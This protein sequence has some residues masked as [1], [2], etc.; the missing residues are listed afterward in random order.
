M[1]D[2][3]S[4]II[5]IIKKDSFFGMLK[6]VW[7]YLKAKN[8]FSFSFSNKINS[9]KN[10]EFYAEEIDKILNN[11]K[12]D[13]V[14]IWRSSFGW[15]VPLYQRPQH[16]FNNLSKQRSLV[17]YEVT[18]VTD[19]VD[20]FQKVKDNLFLVNFNN[21]IFSKILL[22]KIELSNKPRYI[23]FYSTEW[24]MKLK[25]LKKYIEKGYKIIY[26]YIDDLSPQLAGTKELPKNVVDKYNYAMSDNKDIYVVVTADKLYKDAINKRGKNNLVF[27]SNGVDYDFFKEFDKDFKFEKEFEDII[28][29]DKITVGYYGAF[30]KWFDYELVKKIADTDKYNIILFGIK[31]DESFE[32]SG[33]ENYKNIHF[34]GSREYK[35]LKNYA[36]KI[37]ILTIPF[38]INDITEATS[39][40]KIFEYMALKK[41]IVT[42]DMYECKKYKSVLIGKTHEDFINKLDLAFKKREDKQYLKLLDKEAKGNDWS[43]KAKLIIDMISKEE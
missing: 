19:N 3:I 16:I 29:Q 40:V 10:K 38:L 20:A 9:M 6:K 21:S 42:T 37:D 11:E 4:K 41:P 17:F 13:R 34:L 12:Y 15:N 18:T 2:K 33:I 35:Y 14:I 24:H 39:P 5:S 30:A 8:K 32:K 1:K 28:K 26:E 25:N 31:Y 27:S 7:S 22:N 36:K 23:Q 43:K